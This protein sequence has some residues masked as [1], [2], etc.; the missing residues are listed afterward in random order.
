[1]VQRI[2]PGSQLLEGEE[3]GGEMSEEADYNS[4][5]E[6]GRRGKTDSGR[7]LYSSS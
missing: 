3:A 2:I 1:M 6:G 4:V 7:I 5:N